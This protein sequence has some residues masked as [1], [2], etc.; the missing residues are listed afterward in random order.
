MTNDFRGERNWHRDRPRPAELD[1]LGPLGIEIVDAR[2]TVSYDPNK[3][4]IAF[5]GQRED[6]NL[7]PIEGK[8]SVISGGPAV[9]YRTQEAELA[10]TPDELGRLAR[11]SLTPD[12]FFAIC[13]AVGAIFELHDDFFDPDTGEAF[14]PAD[15]DY[16]FT[17]AK[18]QRN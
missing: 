6:K 8:V 9:I 17:P 10:L 16:V 7:V 1:Y 12:E 18:N 13:D 3:V 5:I 15:E 14:Q 4:A 2:G 11:R